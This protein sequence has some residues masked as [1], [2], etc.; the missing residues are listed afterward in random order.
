[1]EDVCRFVATFLFEI[2]PYVVQNIFLLPLFW[3]YT[4]QI[5]NAKYQRLDHLDA[6]V[7]KILPISEAWSCFK[8]CSDVYKKKG[9]YNIHTSDFVVS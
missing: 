9:I 8:L 6:D 7:L 5:T 1:M 3:A 4:L 2:G